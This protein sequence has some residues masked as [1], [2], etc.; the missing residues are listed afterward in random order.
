MQQNMAASL[1]ERFSYVKAKSLLNIPIA[2][3]PRVI[4]PSMLNVV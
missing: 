2:S 1:L 3:A 4:S